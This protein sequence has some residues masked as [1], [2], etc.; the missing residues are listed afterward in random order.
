M[1]HFLRKILKFLIVAFFS[2][3]ILITLL[4][5][6]V[7]HLSKDIK[8]PLLKVLA[9][10]IQGRVEVGS[11]KASFYPAG[12]SLEGVKFFTHD[13][14][15]ASVSVPKM[16][17]YF[18]LLPLL[19]KKIEIHLSVLQ[20]EIQYRQFL[21]EPSNLETL[22]AVLLKE[23]KTFS[24]PM[25]LLWGSSLSLKDF[26][27][28]GAKYFTR[29]SEFEIDAQGFFDFSSQFLKIAEG[30]FLFGNLK[31]N[32][33]AEMFLDDSSV[34]DLKIDFEMEVPESQ[35]F[36]EFF[37]GQLQSKK[38]T[39]KN[40]KEYF[41]EFDLEIGPI[42]LPVFDLKDKV[43][44]AKI[45]SSMLGLGKALNLK[46]L[47]S[48]TQIMGSQI[49]VLTAQLHIDAEKISVEKF[50]AVND[51]FSAT[52]TAELFNQEQLQLTSLLVLN[53]EVTAF[54]VPDAALRSSLTEQTGMIA[55]AVNVSGDVN[56]PQI[57]IGKSY[58]RKFFVKAFFV[59]LKN[60]IFGDSS[61][62][63]FK[64]WWRKIF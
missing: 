2:T 60:K 27:I 37:K 5:F 30:K 19:Q 34:N 52:G 50:K 63:F 58:F 18:Y 42:L 14:K 59:N 32:F 4:L 25:N 10:Q 13:E 64:G 36:P 15:E 54:L 61:E 3:A 39:F 53:S 28:R 6:Y 45:L 31:S 9:N 23:K 1:K 57:K 21:N 44:S 49:D 55:V 12:L 43:R 29:G 47:H 62:G 20:P 16:G 24:V 51:C 33:V 17:L 48:S 8:A 7:F 26:S 35:L 56:D 41:G 11:A 46:Q 22:F 38:F 40:S